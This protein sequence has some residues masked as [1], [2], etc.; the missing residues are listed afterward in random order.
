M[1]ESK[2]LSKELLQEFINEVEN[3]TVKLNIDKTFQLNEVSDAHQYMEDNKSKGK[4]VV[5]I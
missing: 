3:G 5:K 1:G 4:I 2:N